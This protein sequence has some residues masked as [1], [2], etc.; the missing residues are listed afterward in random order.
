MRARYQKARIQ[1][2]L[3][4]YFKT[5]ATTQYKKTKNKMF[6]HSTPL[7]TAKDFAYVHN[8]AGPLFTDDIKPASEP[9]QVYRLR[10]HKKAWTSLSGNSYGI[11]Y[12]DGTPF[13]AD[14]QGLTLTFR[15]RMVLRDS[16]GVVIG[17]MLKM[18]CRMQQTFKIYGLRPFKKGQAPSDQTHYSQALYPWAVITGGYTSVQRVMTMLP[19]KS[20]MSWVH[21]I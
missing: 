2:F 20:E 5:S 15:D 18:F 12:R 19:I 4:N 11:R 10:M 7:P 9:R 1:F 13:E 17:V 6:Q 16:K 8:V 21:S 14:I 3:I